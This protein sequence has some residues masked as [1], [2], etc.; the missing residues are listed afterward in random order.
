[1]SLAPGFFFREQDSYVPTGRGVSP[2][3]GHSMGGLPIAGLCAH[4]IERTPTLSPMH[5]ARLTIDILGAVPMAPLTPIVSIV[6]E[7]KRI[8]LVDV[9][10]T[11]E[12]RIWARASALRMRVEDTP[13]SPVPL[14]RPFPTMPWDVQHTSM[15]ETLRVDHSETA[16]GK[17]A[18]WARFPY[19][20]VVGD[21]VAPLEAAAMIA[22]FGGGIAPLFPIRDWTFANLDISVHMTRLPRGEWLLIDAETHSSGNGVGVSHGRLGDAE[23]MFGMSHQTVFLARR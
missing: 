18:R 13:A 9:A 6:R 21:T 20:V 1:M 10:L 15:S 5:P 8:Q 16:S 12:G 2:W 3:N 14:T 22:D 11:I 23:G 7:G 17:G 19:P 4:L